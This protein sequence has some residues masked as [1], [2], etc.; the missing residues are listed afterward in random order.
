MSAKF[1]LPGLFIAVLSLNVA[2][3]EN[4]S[5]L[6]QPVLID[7]QTV[8]A[9][10]TQVSTTVP[11]LVLDSEELVE[12]VQ[13]EID[14]LEELPRPELEDRAESGER[15]AQVV[16]GTEFAREATMLGFA[17]SAANDALSDAARWYSQ[18][19]AT[20]FPGAPSLDQAGLR[21]FP[22]RIQRDR[23]P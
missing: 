18:A 23:R 12:Q 9:D 19:A 17:P 13:A 21:F 1:R 16:L 10:V 8:S 6:D 11:T 14:D 7:Q 22:I 5:V 20:G 2:A 15:A 3:Q 4:A